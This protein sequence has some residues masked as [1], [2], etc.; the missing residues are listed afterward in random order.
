MENPFQRF[1]LCFT[2]LYILINFYLLFLLIRVVSIEIRRV[3]GPVIATGKL[4]LLIIFNHL[5]A[6]T[7]GGFPNNI[8]ASNVKNEM[9]LT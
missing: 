2:L 3:W 8:R 4:G 1:S 9:S 7:V 6:L 5:L